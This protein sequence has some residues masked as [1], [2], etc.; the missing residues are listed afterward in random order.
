MYTESIYK[1]A[2]TKILWL[3][4]RIKVAIVKGNSARN[5][6]G[7]LTSTAYYFTENQS[8]H[9]TALLW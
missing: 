3:G 9:S 7:S 1:E 5:I 2:Y 4:S 6:Q 8:Q